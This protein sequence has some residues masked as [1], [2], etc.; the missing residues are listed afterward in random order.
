MAAAA[1]TALALGAT[2]LAAV[3]AAQAAAA[4]LKSAVWTDV[5][6]GKVFAAFNLLDDGVRPEDVSLHIR[7]RGSDA[8]LASVKLQGT[9]KCAPTSDCWDSTYLT[10]P[11][12]LPGLGGY[13]VD[14]LVKEGTAEERVRRDRGEVQYGLDAHMVLTP[15]HAWLSYDTPQ[16]TVN[17]TLLA[18]DPDTHET[19]PFAG[20]TVSG[21]LPTDSAGH[22]S[23]RATATEFTPSP[24]LSFETDTTRQQITIPFHKQDLKLAVATPSGTVTAPDGSYIP[25]KGRLTRIADDGTEKPVGLHGISVGGG[26]LPLTAK[27]GTFSGSVGAPVGTV[28]VQ[29]DPF[30]YFNAPPKHTFQV[31]AATSVFTSVKGE[32]DKY[33]K[34]TF[35]GKLG[36]RTG[37]ASP[38]VKLPLH[39]QYSA[40]GRTWSEAGGFTAEY[41]VQFTRSSTRRADVDKAG[42]WRL[43]SG[44]TTLISPSFKL[45]R[46]ATQL[47]NDDVT[48]EPVRKGARITAKGGLLQRSGTSWRAFGGQTV[49]VYFKAATRGATWQRLGTAV[50]RA[51]GTFSRTFTAERDGTWQIRFVDAPA[52]HY[53]VSGREDYV[54]VR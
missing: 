26:R 25:V 1:G 45:G 13:T 46:K 28:T 3:P 31:Q 50:T 11:L 47:F 18:E 35:T 5:H 4:P 38:G 17:G 21:G 9:E 48:P 37:T 10:D 19:K 39:I 53:A 36:T 44:T 29:P 24:T 20:V 14:V 23:A 6:D 52:T 16:V 27:D 8:V 49:R 7:R 40:D 2:T 43:V 22:F 15:D 41:G 30:F 54:D 32:V 12:S 33:R 34:V 42:Y 51:D